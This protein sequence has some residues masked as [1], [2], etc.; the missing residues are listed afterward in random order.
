MIHGRGNIVSRFVYGTKTNV[1][2]YMAKNGDM[3]RILTDHLGS[4]R[5]VVDATAGTVVQQ[6]D[7]DEFGNVVND[8]NLGFQPFGF[9][10][11][12]Y[13]RDTGLLRFGARDYDAMT[14]KWTAK[15]PILF[16]GGDT[17]LFG[18]VGNNP[19][20][21][22]DPLGLW[23]W[24]GNWGGPDWTGGQK[25]TWNSIDTAKAKMPLDK[26]DDCYMGHDMC[27]GSC[28]TH[29]SCNES[30]LGECEINCDRKLVGCLRGLGNDISNDWHAKTATWFFDNFTDVLH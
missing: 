4:P 1:P 23:Q 24:Y 28:R 18:Y 12:L 17:N 30:V 16:A 10:G 27:Y 20:N 22:R 13:D 9:A 3:Y 6:I 5:L 11:G 7:Y 2:D 19:A 8:T 25:E 14:G 26:Q 29:S 21:R 15:D